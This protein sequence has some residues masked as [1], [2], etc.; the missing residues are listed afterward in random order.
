MDSIDSRERGSSYLAAEYIIKTGMLMIDN[1]VN[2]IPKV[3][4]I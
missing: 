4:M 3:F 1:R 2:R